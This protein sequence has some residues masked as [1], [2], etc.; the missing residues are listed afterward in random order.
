MDGTFEPIHKCID[1]VVDLNE[2][3]IEFNPC[4]GKYGFLPNTSLDEQEYYK[5]WCGGEGTNPF[6]CLNTL[7]CS[8]VSTTLRCCIGC[9]IYWAC[10]GLSFCGYC[11]T[12]KCCNYKP[13]KTR[14]EEQEKRN[15]TIMGPPSQS[16]D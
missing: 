11:A 10:C 2:K 1:R 8:T 15:K 14:Y 4:F 9:P 16:I 5:Y 3:I 13:L 7:L 12:N 6:E